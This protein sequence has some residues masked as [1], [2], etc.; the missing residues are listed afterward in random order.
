MPIEDSDMR[1]ID[2]PGCAAADTGNRRELKT[3]LIARFSALGDVAMT[4]PAIYSAARCYPDVNFVM[5]TRPAMVS[6]FVSPPAN[7]TVVGADVKNEYAGIAGLRRLARMLV[8]TYRPDC[9]IDLH[10]V[11]RTRLL[12]LF[13]RMHGVPAE[14][15]FKPRRQRRRLTRRQNKVMLPLTSQRARYREAFYKAGLGNEDTF[16]GLYGGHDKSDASAFAAIT[17]PRPADE[18]WIGIAPFA[19]HDGKVYPPELMEQTVAML[20]QQAD[21]GRRLRIFF[22]GGGPA[23]EEMLGKWAQKYPSATSL[24][25]KRY[26]FAAELALINRL[27]VMVSMD[28]ANMHLAAIAGTPV[29]SIWGATHPYCGF[30]AWRQADGDII[31]IPMECRPCSVFGNKPCYRGDMLCMKAI[32]PQRIFDRIMQ[33]ITKQPVNG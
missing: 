11:L 22:F 9:F 6:V 2:S 16:A 18:A 19:A 10:N 25:G 1:G 29:V 20:Q 27:D 21:A 32:K 3:V 14:R 17:S 28:S 13:L 31:Q 5:V 24:A 7:L 33:H 30:K 8:R 23:E 12:S 26:G 15:I 4:I